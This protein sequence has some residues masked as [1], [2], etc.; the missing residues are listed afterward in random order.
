MDVPYEY[1]FPAIRGIQAQREFY[2]SM[3]P[4][5]LVP[6]LFVFDDAEL[7][8]ELRAQRQL[9]RGRVPEM[10]RYMVEN[11]DSYVFSALTASI[12]ADMRFVA[13]TD[14]GGKG[15]VGL[16]HIPMEARFII[17]DGQHRRAAIQTA[18]RDNPELAD[19]SIAVVFFHDKG[20]ARCQQMFADLNR[21]A[22]RPSRSLSVLYDHRDDLAQIARAV[23][24]S[25][26]FDGL[27]EMERSALSQR[28]LKLF[29][30]SA[31]NTATAAMLHGREGDS[32]SLATHALDYWAALFDRF[33]E[34]R[35]VSEGR[36]TAGEVRETFL[37]SHGV[38]LH[39]LGR[40]GHAITRAHPDDWRDRLGALSTIDWRR[41]YPKWESRAMIG[42]RVSKSYQNVILTTNM[43]KQRIGLELTSEEQRLEDAHERARNAA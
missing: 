30:L 36:L 34:W 21:Y 24:L 9:N 3:C 18:L 13:S 43:I 31:I 41:A 35:A 11:K 14:L 25:P 29:T 38:V 1:I 32:R 40:M 33:P 16:L 27:V 22:I 28:S 6:K 10:V 42:G 5:R 37:H 23:A 39:A 19:E 26:K 8:P 7:V 20:L 2:V 4:L 12:D 17:N 15:L